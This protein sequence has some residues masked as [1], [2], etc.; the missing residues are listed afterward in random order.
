[1]VA[2]GTDPVK[3][4]LVQT[5]V[6]I[7]EAISTPTPTVNPTSTPTQSPEPSQIPTAKPTN[8]PTP[9]P[10][11]KLPQTGEGT[12][13]TILIFGGAVTIA[14]AIFFFVEMRLIR[15]K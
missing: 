7:T 5:T 1:M 12:F 6:D 10:I 13:G 4:A 14:I 8:A 11:N 15:K 3:K 9:T 2:D